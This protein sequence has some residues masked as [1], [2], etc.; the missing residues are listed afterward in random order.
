MVT[1]LHSTHI[2]ELAKEIQA[3]RLHEAKI[4][5]LVAHQRRQWAFS[6][7]ALLAWLTPFAAR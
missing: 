2:F 6:L 3:E 4:A 5:H 1:Q 7:G